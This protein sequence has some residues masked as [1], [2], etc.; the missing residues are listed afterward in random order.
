MLKDTVLTGFI[1]KVVKY[2][3]LL[4]GISIALKVMGWDALIV[5]IFSGAGVLAIVLGFA[6]KDIGENFI[7][8]L[9]LAFNRPFK[10]GD[11]IMLGDQRGRVNK[12][13]IRETRIKTADGKDI[14]IPNASIL[15]G[16][17]INYT[18][19]GYL[20]FEIEISIQEGSDIALC[21]DTILDTLS[22]IEG[23]LEIPAPN[24][25]VSGYGSST[26]NVQ[27]NFWIDLFDERYARMNIRS[28]AHFKVWEALDK[29]GFSL[30]GDVFEVKTFNDQDF[31][32][33]QQSVNPQ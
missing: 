4:V 6:F 13:S 17:L 33:R 1:A 16:N 25:L 15:K 28:Q 5:G 29:A 3:L 23:I 8:G 9:I 12:M 27:Y 30:P 2:A 26:Y 11:L 32:L 14:F 19:D 7:A 10:Q 18:I 22:T 20:R 24:V 31:P 21:R